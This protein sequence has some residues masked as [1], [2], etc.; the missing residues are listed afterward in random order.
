[1]L[2]FNIFFYDFFGG[3]EERG[4]GGVLGW[5]LILA[6]AAVHHLDF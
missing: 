3:G 5:L 2:F 4:E 1:M 6:L